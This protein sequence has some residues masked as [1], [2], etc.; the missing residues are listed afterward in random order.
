MSTGDTDRRLGSSRLG[1][2]PVMTTIMSTATSQ[3]VNSTTAAS[4]PR[5]AVPGPRRPVT[6]GA[7]LERPDLPSVTRWDPSRAAELRRRVRRGELVRVRAGVYAPPPSEKSPALRRRAEVLLA[8]RAALE[9]LT[10]EFWFS[11]E[12]A[13]LLWG[14]W[15]WRLGRDV[16]TTHLWRPTV[17]RAVEPYTRRHT[18]ALPPSDRATLVDTPTGLVIP[19]TSLERTVVDCARTLSPVSG[20]V[21]A[22]AGLRL[23]ADRERIDAL[24]AGAAGA[25]GVRRARHVLGLASAA[26]GSP[27]ESVVRWIVHDAG[28]PTPELDIEVATWAGARWVDL[29]WPELRVGIE[30]DGMV[31]YGGGRYGDPAVR[32]VE[33]KARHDA[34]VE[35]G[36]HLVRVTWDDLMNPERLVARLRA[37]LSRRRA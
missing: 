21:T 2:A 9:K 24:L 17:D 6:P 36:W 4:K 12:S 8:V 27:G 23:G 13:A 35:A 30:F 15:T 31:K 10:G 33:E 20:L 11:H 1:H 16:H 37:A 29:G 22:D 14:C 34:L 26:S 5:P 3:G 19:V 28:L 7:A 18:T 25:R 32:L